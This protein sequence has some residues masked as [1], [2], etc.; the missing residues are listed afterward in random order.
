[1]V[2]DE[3][4]PDPQITIER[5]R[6]VIRNMIPTFQPQVDMDLNKDGLITSFILARLTAVSKK[7]AVIPVCPDCK[8]K[9]FK[10]TRDGALVCQKCL[11]EIPDPRKD[12]HGGREA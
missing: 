3:V 11:K 9:S 8:G 4:L 5:L 7:E 2:V 6:G 12:D 1:M 10:R